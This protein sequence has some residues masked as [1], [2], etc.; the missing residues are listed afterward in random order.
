MFDEIVASLWY[1][2]T[3][4][5]SDKLAAVLAVILEM[6]IADGGLGMFMQSVCSWVPGFTGISITISAVLSL[7]RNSK[8][9]SNPIPYHGGRNVLDERIHGKAQGRWTRSHTGDYGHF[10]AFL[11]WYGFS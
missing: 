9:Y 1:S 8:K 4:G 6:T 7:V 5:E 3:R 2:M 10:D 11:V